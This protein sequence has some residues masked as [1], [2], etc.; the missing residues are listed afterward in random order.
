MKTEGRQSGG[1]KVTDQRRRGE[2]GEGSRRER[3]PEGKGV[4]SGEG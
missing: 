3:G 2:R 1:G 4:Q